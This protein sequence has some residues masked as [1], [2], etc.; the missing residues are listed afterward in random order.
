MN[1]QHKHLFIFG[2]G[3]VAGFLA[4]AAVSLGFKV[5]VSSRKPS[6][7]NAR[8]N[9]AL[10]TF[11]TPLPADITHVVST[12]PPQEGKDPV[13][14]A[15]PTLP[16]G[17]EFIGY[18]SSTGVYG[19]YQGQEVT[20]QSPLKAD[21]PR[22][23]ARLA[24]EAQW[25]QLDRPVHVFRLSGIYGPGRNMLERLKTGKIEE[26]EKSDR[27]VNRIHVED[28]CQIVLAACQRPRPQTEIYN[29]ADDHPAPTYE[30]LTYAAHK[31]GVPL[32]DGT[33]HGSHLHDGARVVN[34]AKAKKE[35]GIRW[36]YP[37]YKHGLDAL[38]K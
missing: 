16:A 30:V 20:E 36:K 4:E 18:L 31:L 37:T 21:A 13:L 27:P 24:A 5:T 10:H 11:G 26:L 17:V 29:V 9:I 32:K 22:S 2:H 19:D 23:L 33:S 3:Y 28:I 8:P 1:L 35:W 15:Y 34:C 6:K 38:L 7:N 14:K 25:L 12:V